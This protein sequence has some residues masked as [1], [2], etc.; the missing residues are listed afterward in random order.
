MITTLKIII[1]IASLVM[2]ASRFTKM[3]NRN[4]VWYPKQIAAS[5]LI[6][7]FFIPAVFTSIGT[8][9][10]G[11][12]G[13]VV[14]L[15]KVTGRV[16]GE[17]IYIVLPYMEWVEQ[18]N[19]QILKESIDAT[20]SSKDLQDVS[21]QVALNYRLKADRVASVYQDLRQ[22][23]APRIIDPA[24]QEAVKATTARYSAEQLI[25]M[26][27][28]VREGIQRALQARLDAHNISIDAMSIT[29]FKFSKVFSDTIEQ[30]VVMSQQA[31]RAQRELE[32]VK[33]ESE[34]AVVKARAEAEGLRAQ[35]E[36]ITDMLLRLRM[37]ENERAAIAKWNG[38]LPA[39][40]TAGAPIPFLNLSPSQSQSR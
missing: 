23:W 2:L 18:M 30:K 25:T 6:W 4:R 9:D 32:K 22:E 7:L 3:E 20:A 1:A 14:R 36:E 10:P 19:V 17:G 35:R 37:V 16:L 12:R 24:I 39:Y 33:F 27:E 31:E 8:V 13:V 28:T 26:R 34:Q 11:Y 21:T 38:S 15:G 40:I 29:D 5:V